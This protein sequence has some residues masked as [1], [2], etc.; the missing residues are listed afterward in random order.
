[1]QKKHHLLSEF[2]SE[3]IK[4]AD[5]RDEKRW[6]W[7]LSWVKHGR[8][9]WKLKKYLHLSFPPEG[10]E[11]K[12][13]TFCCFVILVLYW[14]FNFIPFVIYSFRIYHLSLT[15]CYFVNLVAKFM[16]K[17]RGLKVCQRRNRFRILATGASIQRY[18]I[19][20][21]IVDETMSPAI[22]CNIQLTSKYESSLIFVTDMMM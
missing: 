8:T 16:R 5:K 2:T 21:R 18:N 9:R 3:R 20:A 13:E 19:V 1:M 15:D 11:S 6:N 10:H 14:N 22:M 12:R 17:M 4:C 7:I